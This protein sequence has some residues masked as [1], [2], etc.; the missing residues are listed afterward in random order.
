MHKTKDYLFVTQ[1]MEMNEQGKQAHRPPTPA[2]SWV[3]L[4]NTCRTQSAPAIREHS[5]HVHSFLVFLLSECILHAAIHAQGHQKRLKAGAPAKH[6]STPCLYSAQ[7]PRPHIP[8]VFQANLLHISQ[9]TMGFAA[10]PVLP[11]VAYW[12]R[13]SWLLL[14]K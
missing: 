10:P 5:L 11:Q 13:E 9:I 2:L 12:P 14:G 3:H 1:T 4:L 8:F 6:V 7:S